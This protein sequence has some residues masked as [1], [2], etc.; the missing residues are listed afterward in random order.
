MNTQPPPFRPPPSP[1]K[2]T[3]PFYSAYHAHGDARARTQVAEV[4]SKLL[5]A[6]RQALADATTAKEK[7]FAEAYVALAQVQVLHARQLQRAYEALASGDAGAAMR[8]ARGE[9]AAVAQ[10]GPGAKR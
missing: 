7:L 1:E 2:P 4:W 8:L 3:N 6:R 9:P 5:D 10:I